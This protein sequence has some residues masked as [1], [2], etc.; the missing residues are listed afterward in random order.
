M[1]RDKPFRGGTLVD[2]ATHP[3]L[4]ARCAPYRELLTT[5]A[6]AQPG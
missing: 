6:A 3:E 1:A 5:R 4:M 2:A